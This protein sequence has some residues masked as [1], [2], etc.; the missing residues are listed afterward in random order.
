MTAI[1]LHHISIVLCNTSHPGNIGATARAMKTMGLTNLILVN[2]QTVVDDHAYAMSSNAIDVLNNIKICNSL[3]E[4]I[5]DVAIAYAVTARHR[6]FAHRVFTPRG[7][8]PELFTFLKNDHKIAIVFGAERTGLTIEQTELCNRIITIPGNPE[9]F[10]L[11]LSQAVQIISYEIYSNL[12]QADIFCNNMQ[13]PINPCTRFDSE[14]LLN[15]VINTIGNG[16]YFVNKNNS[17]R[18]I[19]IRRLRNI[20]NK[21]NLE[22]HEVDLIYGIF[23]SFYK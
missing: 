14:Y 5:S 10:S 19:T 7:M 22:R 13:Q 3:L 11:N 16:S 12:E 20:I 6:E 15:Y 9:Y 1:N 8:I 23:K 21:A 17:H 4:A 2:P 18:S